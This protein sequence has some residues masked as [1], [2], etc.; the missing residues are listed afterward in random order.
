MKATRTIERV[1]WV[2]CLSSRFWEALTEED[3]DVWRVSVAVRPFVV[4]LS[5]LFF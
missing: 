5:Y 4:N 2:S 3:F 1:T